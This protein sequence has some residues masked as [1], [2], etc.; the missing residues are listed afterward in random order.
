MPTNLNH[1]RTPECERCTELVTCRTA[2]SKIVVATPCRKGGIL[3][4]GEAPGS[5]EDVRGIGFSGDAGKTLRAL[6]AGSKL[7]S[8]DFVWLIFADV[9]HRKIANLRQMKCPLVC[10]I[11]LI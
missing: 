11:S 4:I 6:L 9:V 8:S 2:S 1:W 10:P 3:A 5:E 7:T